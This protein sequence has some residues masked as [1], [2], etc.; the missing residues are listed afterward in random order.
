MEDLSMKGRHLLLSFV[1]ALFPLFAESRVLLAD[2]RCL[3]LEQSQTFSFDG[4]LTHQMFAGPPNFESVQNGDRAEPS[5]ILRL[6]KPVCVSGNAAPIDRIQ[7]YPGD[8]D[9]KALWARLRG[10][11]GKP[12]TA[13]GNKAFEAFTG[14]HH[15]PLLLQITE[16]RRA[17]R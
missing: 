1:I 2:E 6:Q 9:D 4:L 15:A 3:D 14:H 13:T 10:L 7:I 11:I 17:T 16:V 12:V 8:P 5:Y